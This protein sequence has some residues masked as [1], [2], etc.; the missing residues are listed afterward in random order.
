MRRT[1]TIVGALL[2]CATASAA[3]AQSSDVT[4]TLL[5]PNGK[6]IK[7]YPVVISGTYASGTP[8]YWVTTTDEAG[9]FKFADLPAGQYVVL[10]GNDPDAA[11]S[12][13]LESNKTWLDA[14]TATPDTTEKD[15]G[16]IQVDPGSKLRA[17]ED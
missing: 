5:L 4:G 3:W 12:F 9:K 16:T 2:L 11:K 8:Q 17:P 14:L 7:G 13:E 6:A 10:P 15:V 1:M